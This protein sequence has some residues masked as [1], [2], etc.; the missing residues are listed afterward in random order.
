METCLTRC[1]V[2]TQ[3]DEHG[4]PLAIGPPATASLEGGSLRPLAAQASAPKRSLN[5]I[6]GS[7]CHAS[8]V[9]SNS[10]NSSG[11]SQKAPDYAA[12]TASQRSM[13]LWERVSPG[14]MP[15]TTRTPAATTAAAYVWQAALLEPVD[16]T[17]HLRKT[18]FAEFIECKLRLMHHIAAAAKK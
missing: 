9:G 5:S 12:V 14:M 16:T 4:T 1:C 6:Q 18:D 13:A 15:G 8:S 17:H 11:S 7:T 3:V 2:H 10:S